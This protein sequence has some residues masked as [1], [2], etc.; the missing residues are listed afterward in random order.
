MA[1]L[2]VQDDYAFY[3]TS[4]WALVWIH[5]GVICHYT[6][7]RLNLDPNGDVVVGGE[8]LIYASY[9]VF[10]PPPD[11]TPPAFGSITANTAVAGSPV[12]LNCPV[13]DNVAVSSY[14]LFVEQHG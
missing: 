10:Y 4:T 2:T 6:E 13:S 9:S 11:T 7:S 1:T 8:G 12:Q 5:S 14:L 3:N